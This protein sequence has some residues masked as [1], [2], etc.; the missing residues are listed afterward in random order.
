MK[1]LFSKL[2]W[3]LGLIGCLACGNQTSSLEGGTETGN[4]SKINLRVIAYQNSTLQNVLL[5][6]LIVGTLNVTQAD[7]VLERIRFRPIEVCEDETL[8]DNG[9][10][11]F[12][13]PFI[14][15]LLDPTN[16]SNLVGVG[17]PEDVYCR[18]E[19]RLAKLEES[20][21]SPLAGKSVVISGE[22]GDGT[23][24][25]VTLNKDEEFE[26]ENENTGFELSSQNGTEQVFIA[27]DLDQWFNNVDL[28][29]PDVEI[30][31]GPD[32]Q[33]IILLEEGHNQILLEQIIKNLELSSDLFED[34]D[35][36]DELDEAEQE[37]SLA[38]GQLVP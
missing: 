8:D 15:D 3:T 9:E 29:A 6:H 13:G 16:E 22:R 19:L 11:R 18:I 26:L 32:G 25:Q 20:V 30:S 1:N 17:I 37:N 35:N 14:V 27:F 21:S 4:P 2:F 28:D 38:Q 10:I 31:L 24:F 33:P 34:S 5:P 7:I 23:P 36:D 12:D